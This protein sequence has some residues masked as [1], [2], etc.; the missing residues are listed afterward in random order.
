VAGDATR[1]LATVLAKGGTIATYGLLSGEPCAIEAGDLVFR[2]I[3]LKGFWLAPWLENAEG[4]H[5]RGMYGE[6]ARLVAQNRLG[7]PV[8]ATYGFDRHVDALAHAGQEHR[9]GKILFVGSS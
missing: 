2:D 9:S 7:A 6:L 1:Q 8:E 4:T 5:L 3:T